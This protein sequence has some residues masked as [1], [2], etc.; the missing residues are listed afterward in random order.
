MENLRFHHFNR[1]FYRSVA[2]TPEFQCF[3][4]TLLSEHSLL[5]APIVICCRSGVSGS[6]ALQL[7]LRDATAS[8]SEF[9]TSS[10]G[11]WGEFTSVLAAW[12]WPSIHILLSKPSFTWPQPNYKRD[13]KCQRAHG[14]LVL[15][16]IFS[17]FPRAY[18]SFLSFQALFLCSRVEVDFCL[19]NTPEEVKH[20]LLRLSL[21]FFLMARFRQYSLKSG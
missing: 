9:F 10:Q 15:G 12:G 16:T 14:W 19:P 2:Q 5:L 8:I 18:K 1:Q 21:F 13:W 11:V 17:M 7:C 20:D 6:L 3:N 4:T